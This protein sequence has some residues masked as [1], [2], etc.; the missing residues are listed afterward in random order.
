MYDNVIERL[1]SLG[2]TFVTA[3][4]WVLQFLISKVTNEIKNECNTAEVP[5]G[6]RQIAVDM[7]CGEFLM[8]KETGEVSSGGGGSSTVG[9]EI[10]TIR[11]G[12]TTVEYS[13]TTSSS[14]GVQTFTTIDSLISWLLNHG[15]SQFTAHRKMRW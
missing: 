14:G 6:L 7:V 15:R 4:E 11:S 13:V 1:L 5:H 10:K 3:D 12:D 8:M 9:G 2:Y